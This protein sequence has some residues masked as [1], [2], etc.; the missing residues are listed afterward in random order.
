MY[1]SCKPVRMI[2]FHQILLITYIYSTCYEI[3]KYTDSNYTNMTVMTCHLCHVCVK[4]GTTLATKANCFT[5]NMIYIYN[6][7]ISIYFILF[8]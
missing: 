2:I 8:Y 1:D 7:T 3:V 6:S 5:S 4:F